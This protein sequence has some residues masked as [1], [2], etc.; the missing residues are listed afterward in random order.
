MKFLNLIL[1]STQ[2][3]DQEIENK[4]TDV[5]IEFCELADF[6][7]S[8]G[9]EEICLWKKGTPIRFHQILKTP[10]LGWITSLVPRQEK[11][12]VLLCGT[13]GC[14]MVEVKNNKA[15]VAYS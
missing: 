12:C 13:K 11:S 7:I 5:V 15:L 8:A 1:A 14:A 3:I 10:G 6:F 2:K 4:D 9:N